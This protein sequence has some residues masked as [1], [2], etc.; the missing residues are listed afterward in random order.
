MPGTESWEGYDDYGFYFQGFL[1]GFV[2]ITIAS[3]TFAAIAFVIV[4]LIA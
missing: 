2:G 1:K 4:R 3:A